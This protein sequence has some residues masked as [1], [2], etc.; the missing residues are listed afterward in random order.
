MKYLMRIVCLL[1]ALL[2]ATPAMAWD[3]DEEYYFSDVVGVGVITYDNVPW[4]FR[5]TS[6][7]W[8]R[9]S[10]AWST[11]ICS[12]RTILCPTSWWT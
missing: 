3:P 4:E 11:S 9:P 12:S 8:T 7:I 10:S 2:L 6:P 1:A 5:W